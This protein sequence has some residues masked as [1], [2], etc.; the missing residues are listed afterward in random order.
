MPRALVVIDLQN[1][2]ISSEGRFPIDDT[3]KQSLL[4]NLHALVPEFRKR[5]H[6]VW[7]KS[8]YANASTHD[9]IESPP[10]ATSVDADAQDAF[11]AGTHTGR[12]PCC[13]KGSVNAEFLPEVSN[14]IENNS[15]AVLVKTWY[16]VFKETSLLEDLR[17][18]RVTD[19]YFCGLLTN[20]CVLASVLDALKVPELSVHVV[21]D[22]LGWRRQT[23]H[24]KALDKMGALDVKV[25]KG[26]DML[27]STAEVAPCEGTLSVPELYY[28]NGSIPSWRVQLALYEK[29]RLSNS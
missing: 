6:V 26:S 27:G 29:V 13:E 21:E 14:L 17:E 9:E 12:S 22:C 25:V 24:Q 8:N 7:I 18:K 10:T 20:I 15:D 5:G 2:F 28:V 23:S 4:T 16:S 19:V 11:L 1:E 3:S